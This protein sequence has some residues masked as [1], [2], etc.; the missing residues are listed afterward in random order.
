VKRTASN[1]CPVCDAGDP[2]SVVSSCECQEAPVTVYE[3]RFKVSLAA[4]VTNLLEKY[5]DVVAPNFLSWE[6]EALT[7][8]DT[9]AKLRDLLATL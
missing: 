8:A 3:S 2:C 9:S 1:I 6:G 5:P 7:G 4:R